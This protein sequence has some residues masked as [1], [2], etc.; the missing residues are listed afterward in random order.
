MNNVDNLGLK[1]GVVELIDYDNDYTRIYLEEKENLKRILN[2]K[3]I[4]I[5]HVGSTAIKNIKSK[6][7]I[8]IL[9][10][11]KDLLEFQNFVKENVESETYTLKE[12]QEGAQDFLIRKEEDGKVKAFIHVVLEDSA[13]AQEYILFRDYL[14]KYPEEAKKYENLKLELLKKYKDDRPKYTEGKHEYIRNIIEKAKN[15]ER[16]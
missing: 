6:P 12:I 5:E 14:N 11:C 9:V 3:Y 7:I 16:I 2:G 15:E 1:K 13:I 10:T 4:R 8:D